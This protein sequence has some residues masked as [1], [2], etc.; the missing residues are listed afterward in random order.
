MKNKLRIVE[1]LDYL[2]AVSD[3]EIKEGDLVPVGRRLVTTQ[4]NCGIV[5]YLSFD[6]VAFLY[7]TEKH[8]PVKAHKPKNNSPE[9]DLP[10]LPEFFQDDVEKSITTKVYSEEDLRK[11]I[12]YGFDVGFC[13][14]SRNKIKNNLQSE[15]EFIKSLKQT[16]T[17]KWFVAE[18]VDTKE[19]INYEYDGTI[20]G[21]ITWKQKFKTVTQEGQEVLIGTYLFE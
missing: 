1:T 13:S 9:L 21:C 19:V 6:G 20:D 2:L 11:A 10:L 14:N 3:E 4:K 12:R 16:K 17:P 7:F 15:D 5:G 8:K 18:M